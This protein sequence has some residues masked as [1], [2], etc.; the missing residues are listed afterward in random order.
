MPYRPEAYFLLS[1]FHER[2]QQY[3]EAY[4]WAEVGLHQNLYSSLP[5]S[6]GFHGQYCLLFEKAVSAWWIGRADESKELFIKLSSME[7]APEYA[8]AVRANLERFNNVDV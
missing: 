6:V 2:L 7:L 5:V 8:E 1:Q 4:T 3:Q